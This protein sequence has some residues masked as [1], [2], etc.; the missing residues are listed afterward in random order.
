M[1]PA[2]SLFLVLYAGMARP[3]LPSLISELFNYA[4]FRL[5]ILTLIVFMGGQDIQLSLII[6]IGFTVTMNLLSEQKIKEE[7]QSLKLNV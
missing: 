3:E 4:A 1:T 7:F 6:A 5:I 2:A